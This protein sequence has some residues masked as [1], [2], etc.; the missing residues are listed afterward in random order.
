[1]AIVNSKKSFKFCLNFLTKLFNISGIKPYSTTKTYQD[2][3]SYRF[4]STSFNYYFIN[5][6]KIIILYYVILY[7]IVLYYII[8]YYICYIILY[9][10]ILYQ[11]I[12][13]F[14][15]TSSINKETLTPTTGLFFP[16]MSIFHINDPFTL[17][18]NNIKFSY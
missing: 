4:G 12:E 13:A 10:I 18:T 3:Q 17:S 5:L 11:I 15:N 14:K 6:R 8:L 2:V 16:T 9:Y 1:M 7:C